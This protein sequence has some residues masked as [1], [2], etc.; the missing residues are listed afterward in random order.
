MEGSCDRATRDGTHVLGH[1]WTV[2]VE[3]SRESVSEPQ[4]RGNAQP[5]YPLRGFP[6]L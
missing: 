6:R 2:T 1:N 3:G 5:E 4:A